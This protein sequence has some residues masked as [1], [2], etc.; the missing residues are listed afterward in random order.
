[1]PLSQPPN[2]QLT[3]Q[4]AIIAF[5]VVTTLW[6]LTRNTDQFVGDRDHSLPF[7]GWYK[8]KNKQVFYNSP[9]RES[10][11]KLPAAI[12]AVAIPLFLTYRARRCP[13]PCA[14]CTNRG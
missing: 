10:G 14:I 3:L 1:M 13:C 5:A 9:G 4:L 2:H 11:L 8:D 7:G 12:L 6:A